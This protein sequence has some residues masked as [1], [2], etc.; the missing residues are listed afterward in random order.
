MSAS[1]PQPE[2]LAQHPKRLVV[3]VAEAV[4]ESRLVRDARRLGALGYTVTDVRGGG[5]HESREASFSEDRNVR[6]DV[7]AEEATAE[8]IAAHV[9]AAYAK[10][11]RLSLYLAD[12]SVLRPERY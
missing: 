12:V 9:L 5:V 7:V 6:I 10:D 8:A 1:D 2:R 4:L 11:Y 3:I